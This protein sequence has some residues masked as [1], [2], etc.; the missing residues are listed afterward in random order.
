MLLTNFQLPA[1]G[2]IPAKGNEKGKAVSA[3]PLAAGC[4]AGCL[5]WG[6]GGAKLK[7]KNGRHGI[8]VFLLQTL[9]RFFQL[10]FLGSEVNRAFGLKL[11]NE[12]LH[13]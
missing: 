1:T 7:L 3:L 8:F 9:T 5:G 10:L 2:D 6:I 11:L 4:H 13:L 12:M